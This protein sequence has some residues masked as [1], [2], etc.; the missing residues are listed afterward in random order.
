MVGEILLGTSCSLLFWFRASDPFFPLAVKWTGQVLHFIFTRK[1]IKIVVKKSSLLVNS[2]K[3]LS[4][5]LFRPPC[6]F[7]TN[8]EE[9]L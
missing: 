8:V 9:K 1:T 3:N 6:N 4:G 5:E 2:F 7:F